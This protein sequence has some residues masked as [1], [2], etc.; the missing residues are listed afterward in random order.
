MPAGMVL[1]LSFL[2]S[3][4]Q[5]VNNCKLNRIIKRCLL[6]FFINSLRNYYTIS[7]VTPAKNTTVHMLSNT[8]DA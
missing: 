1:L 4:Q 2:N 8:N 7:V 3:V 5:L 6:L